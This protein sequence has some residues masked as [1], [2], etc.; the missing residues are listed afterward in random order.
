MQK[1]WP[2]IRRTY[3]TVFHLDETWLDSPHRLERTPFK[4]QQILSVSGCAFSEDAYWVKS[5]TA[6][7]NLNLTS[8]DRLNDLVAF[9]FCAA[10]VNK[11]TLEAFAQLSKDWNFEQLYFRSEAWMQGAE[12]KVKDLLKSDVV[13][14]YS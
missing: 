2:F 11:D 14:D 1:A 13:A 6:I 4:V 3:M 10:S 9:F 5:A 8:H 7:F 12:N